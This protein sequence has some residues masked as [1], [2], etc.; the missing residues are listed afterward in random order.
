VPVDKKERKAYSDTLAPDEKLVAKG[1]NLAL[2]GAWT[3]DLEGT[4]CADCH[5]TIGEEFAVIPEDEVDGAP[6][7]AKYASEAWLKDFIRNPSAAHHYGDSNQMPAYPPNQLTDTE[8]DLLVRWLTHN[9]LPTKVEDYPDRQE[10]LEKAAS[11]NSGSN[12]D[13]GDE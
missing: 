3:G 11:G 2:E 13:S 9:H 1:R 10:E 5:S 12:E 7:L 8:L 6:T 4:S